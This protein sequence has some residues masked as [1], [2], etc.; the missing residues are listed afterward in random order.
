MDV[1][2]LISCTKGNLMQ[3]HLEIILDH[4]ERLFRKLMTSSTA[5]RT[6]IVCSVVVITRIE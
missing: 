5:V 6:T 3:I 1:L 2:S 4:T